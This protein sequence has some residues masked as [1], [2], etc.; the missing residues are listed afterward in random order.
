[1]TNLAVLSP[2][3]SIT[4]VSNAALMNT[5]GAYMLQYRLIY[6]TILRILMKLI[7]SPST[8]SK[9]GF[10]LSGFILSFLPWKT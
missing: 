4:N 2:L 1:M 3:L 9:S 7:T 5:R 8:F 6:S 10:I